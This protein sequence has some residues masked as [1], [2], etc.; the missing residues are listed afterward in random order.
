MKSSNKINIGCG[1]NIRKG[2]LNLDSVKLPNVDV[3]HDLN[4][5]PWPL[6]DNT[7]DEVLCDN[8]LEHLDSII[9]PMEEIWRISR[10]KNKIII[11]VPIYPSIWA[12]ADPTHKQ[13]FTYMT[14][15]YFRPEDSLNYYSKARFNIIKRKI[16][17]HKLLSPLTWFFNLSEQMQK[18]YYIFLSSILPAN[19]LYFELKTLKK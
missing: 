3:V 4:K 2:Y 15:N 18:F 10:N 5:Y 17:F 14:F 12:M 19:S 13:F 9:E 16:V 6:K 8:V 1:K 11:K 7:F